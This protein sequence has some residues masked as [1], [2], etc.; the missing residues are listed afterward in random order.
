MKAM[1]TDSF[2]TGGQYD[3]RQHGASA[4]QC[5][6]EKPCAL[7]EAL[8]LKGRN[9]VSVAF[10]GEVECTVTQDNHAA[11][12]SETTWAKMSADALVMKLA[13]ARS[14]AL[15]RKV[16]DMRSNYPY[17]LLAIVHRAELV[18]RAHA[19]R[20]CPL[21]LDPW[22]RDCLSR[23]SDLRS[24]EA[25]A[26]LI[27]DAVM[28]RKETVTIARNRASSRMF[29]L[30]EVFPTQVL[31]PQRFEPEVPRVFSTPNRATP[32]AAR[33]VMIRPSNL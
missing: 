6:K 26:E 32:G 13:L 23:N 4:A 2:T 7:S 15:A 28:G 24:A 22:S 31:G 5:V 11:M 16:L 1:S 17:T 30:H 25:R 3:W 27:A 10:D 12:I 29:F 18:D 20:A 8:E 33:R 9:H 21:R 14:S 19:S